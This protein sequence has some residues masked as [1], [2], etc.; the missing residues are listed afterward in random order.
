MTTL[1]V[2]PAVRA[3]R[4]IARGGL[5]TTAALAAMS[6]ARGTP[7][8]DTLSESDAVPRVVVSYADLNLASRSDADRLLQRIAHAALQVCGDPTATLD[9]SA[10]ARKRGC[11]SATIASAVDA[12]AA[13]K[14]TLA[15][16]QSR[17]TPRHGRPLSPRAASIAAAPR[18]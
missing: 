6:M 15:Y 1:R 5:L 18:Q 14:L 2:T 7:A 9:L 17:Y 4:T 13:E 12:V 8:A 16:S 10:R 11:L 3:M